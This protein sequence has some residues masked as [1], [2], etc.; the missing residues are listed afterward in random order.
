MSHDA[1]I[2]GGVYFK[3]QVE[4]VAVL[5]GFPGPVPTGTPPDLLQ[6]RFMGTGFL[7][8]RRNVFEAM[9]EKWGDEMMYIDEGTKE[10]HWHFWPLAVEPKEH[11][12]LSEDWWFCHRANQLGF[13]VYADTKCV[14]EHLGTVAFPIK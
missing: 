9:I 13:K 1:D 6:V 5:E 8:V 7:R 12:L 3:K 14:V 11:R 10:P 2:V 4:R